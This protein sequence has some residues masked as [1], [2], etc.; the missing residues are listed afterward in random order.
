M[1]TEGEALAP[2]F[3][4]HGDLGL[5]KTDQISG[6]SLCKE[7]EKVIDR[8]DIDGIQRIGGLWRLYIKSEEAKIKL[9]GEGFS[10]NGLT[11]QLSSENP[12]LE[13]DR[14]E[15]KKKRGVK[16]YVQNLPLSVSNSDIE[17]MLE[18]LG[19]KMISEVVYEY[20]RD[21]NRQETTIKNGTRSV[22]IESDYLALNPIQR[23][24]QCCNW[25]CR[26][27]YRDQPNVEKLCFHCC[28]KGHVANQCKNERACKVCQKGG[29]DEG[30][31]QCL[32]FSPNTTVVFKGEDDILSN[33]HKCNMEWNGQK[34]ASLEH[35]YQAEKASINGR[36][37]IAEEIR[38]AN[39]AVDA[40]YLA[41]KVYTAKL[42][43]ES[44]E[45][46]MY[47]MLLEKVKQ[48]KE[49]QEELMKSEGEIIAECVPNQMHWSCGLSKEAA[50]H[51]DP[52]KWPGRNILGRMWIKIRNDM[53]AEIESNKKRKTRESEGESMPSNRVRLNGTT[54]DKDAMKQTGTKI[55][56]PLKELS[57]R[58]KV[59]APQ[60][61]HAERKIAKKK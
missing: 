14:Q 29:H 33:F 55:P 52:E 20:E 9:L 49:V 44:N 18:K 42:W 34:Y 11:V 45:K 1:A 19:A 17:A 23:F 40:K 24:A 4:K 22:L 57:V 30:S 31:A 6:Y 54:P 43:E 3:M 58:P 38:Q 60:K 36:P 37:D 41:R 10:F 35:A 48:N 28:E 12:F 5:S 26:L 25:R 21:D 50:T 47:E 59:I 53:C 16:L 51:T 13:R 2:V 8:K 61:P 27:Y 39:K 7:L 56:S 32:F 15:E 46:L